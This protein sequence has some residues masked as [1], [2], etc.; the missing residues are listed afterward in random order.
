MTRAEFFRE[1]SKIK[2]AFIS[3]TDKK[4]CELWKT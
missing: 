2:K 4:L 3:N 1:M